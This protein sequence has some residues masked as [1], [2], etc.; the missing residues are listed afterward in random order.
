MKQFFARQKSVLLSLIA[1]VVLIGILIAVPT[2]YEDALIYQ[3]TERA[4]GKVVKTDNSA[5]KPSGLVQSGEQSCTLEIEGGIFKGR[6]LEGVNFLSG[7]L[8][9]DKIYKVGD[10]ALLTISYDGDEVKSVVM[11]DH[12]RLDKEMILLLV[13]AVFLI[14]FAGKNGFQAI[15]SFVITVLMIWKVLVPCYLKGYSPVWVGIAIVTAITAVIIFFVYGLDKRTVAATS[16]S[17]LGILTTC[18]L[19]ICFTDLFQIHG[20]IMS[21]AESLLY[22]GY[23][24]LDLTAI[25]MSSIFIGASGAMM[26]LAVDITSAIWEVIQ[27]KPD[28]GWKE[29]MKSGIHVGQAAMGTMTTTLLLAYSGGC[30][31]LLMVFMAQGT[32]IDHILNY[33]YVSAEV[34]ETVVGSFGL[35]TVAPF[36]ALTAGILLTKKQK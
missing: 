7:S 22:S 17:L 27:K 21:N 15:L 8:E 5:I 20:A 18:I 11:S 34:L 33:K 6:T 13:F 36:T 32:P 10:R 31:A 26:D 14:I 24:D 3:G 23:Q 35:V 29:A 9:Q 19:G 16:G 25:F 30:I 28:I 12:Y 4:V 1:A 2:G